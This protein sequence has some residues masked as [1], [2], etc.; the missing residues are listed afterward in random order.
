MRKSSRPMAPHVLAAPL[1]QPP[2]GTGALPR[3]LGAQSSVLSGRS[4][5]PTVLFLPAIPRMPMGLYVA[6][7]P[8]WRPPL[9]TGALPGALAAQTSALF[10][11]SER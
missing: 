9:G 10:D 5:R 1:L 2:L 6:A 7:A 3:A 8:P 4:E 11:R